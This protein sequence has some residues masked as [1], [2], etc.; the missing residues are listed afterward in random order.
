M[1][2]SFEY[3]PPLPLL[4]PNQQTRHLS[5][6]D[7]AY[8]E[9][10]RAA[11]P[12][13]HN[14]LLDVWSKP[15]QLHDLANPLACEAAKPSQV[16]VIA[17]FAP[18]DHVLELNCQSHNLCYAGQTPVSGR[19]RIRRSRFFRAAPPVAYRQTESQLRC[20]GSSCFSVS[21]GGQLQRSLIPLER[22]PRVTVPVLPS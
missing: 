15:D 1:T 2:D 8:W 13:L 4:F 3:P 22:N 16:C 20:F 7:L 11:G 19:R 14:F 18:L 5:Q 21:A 10:R 17:R 9:S 6:S 12:E